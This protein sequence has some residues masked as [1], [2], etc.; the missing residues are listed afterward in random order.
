MPLSFTATLATAPPKG[1][2]KK[3]KAIATTT[4]PPATG[5]AKLRFKLAKLSSGFLSRR[6]DVRVQIDVTAITADG[7]RFPLSLHSGSPG[8]LRAIAA[9]RQPASAEDPRQAAP[10]ARALTNARA[11]SA[12]AAGAAT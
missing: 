9:A 5:P 6:P 7:R 4:A 2:A 1:S 8:P 10:P 3:G 11:S 12:T